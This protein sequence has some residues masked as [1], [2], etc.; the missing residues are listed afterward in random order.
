MAGVTDVS[1][2]NLSKEAL[3]RR[4]GAMRALYGWEEEAGAAEGSGSITQG[5]NECC[6]CLAPEKSHA[7][8]PC[9]HYCVCE[10]CAHCIMAAPKECPVCR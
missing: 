6:V 10:G 2:P 4:T 8:V 7:F 9:G 3:E 5:A 1:P